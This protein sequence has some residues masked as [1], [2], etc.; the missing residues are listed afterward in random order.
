MKRVLIAVALVSLVA[1][2]AF[3]HSWTN[4]SSKNMRSCADW[5]VRIDGY[6]AI[7]TSETTDVPAAGK[8]DVRAAHNGGITVVRGSGAGYRVTL[9]KA[10][11]PDLG[12]AALS[13]ITMSNDSGHLSVDAPGNRGWTAHFIIEAPAGAVLKL[14]AHN[15]PI[16]VSE[17]KGVLDATTVNGPLSLDGVTGTINGQATNGPVTLERASG[18]VT[19]KTTNGPLSVLL[20]Q[21]TWQG[22]GLTASTTNGPL[23][24]DVP[25]GFASGTEITA[26]GHNSWDCPEALC[27]DLLREIE[28]DRQSS[29][30][31]DS[32][33]NEPRT[34]RFGSGTPVVRMSTK[35]G[36]V[37]IDEK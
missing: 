25:R 9:C 21:M 23:S 3:A 14:T 7:V 32:W 29:R 34:L 18:D 1:G 31:H 2:P 27:G 30:R 11:V 10:V 8:L 13:E 12:E 6:D 5:N 24:L 28:R 35:N 4:T 33:N 36:P 20:D 15:G 37:S 26:R 22:S 19:V 16:S 17:F